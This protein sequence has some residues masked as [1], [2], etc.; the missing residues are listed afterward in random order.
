MDLAGTKEREFEIRNSRHDDKNMT[1][2]MMTS[3]VLKAKYQ[4]SSG[5]ESSRPAS[6]STVVL[7]SLFDVF[8]GWFIICSVNSH[9]M[10][11]TTATTK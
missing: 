5:C 6:S 7:F 10:I 8:F 9:S 4:D 2:Q 3:V 1:H 11:K